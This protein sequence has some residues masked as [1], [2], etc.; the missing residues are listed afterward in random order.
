MK[1]II[2]KRKIY[3]KMLDWKSWSKGQYALLIEGA[4]RIGKSTIAEEFARNEYEDYLI[5]DFSTAKKEVIQAFDYIY[6]LDEFFLILNTIYRKKLPEKKSVIIF[7]EIQFCPKARQAIKHLVKDGRYDYIET[8]SLIS[9]RKNT[10]D[11]LIPSEEHRL[12]MYPMDFEEFLWAIGKAPTFDLIKHSFDKLKP[13]G[14]AMHRLIMTDFR[15]FLLIGGMP[16]SVVAFIKSNDFYEVDRIKREILSLYQEDFRKI[17][18]LGR[19]S[20]IFSSIPSQLSRNTKGFNIGNVIENGRPSRY[21]EIFADLRE[22]KTVN[23]AY[24]AND[25]GIGLSL[26]TDFDDFKMYLAD[27]GLFVSLIY[28]D[29]DYTEN[30]IYKKLLF[31]KLPSDLGFIYE[32]VVAQLLLS[33]GHSLH[34]YTFKRENPDTGAIRQYEID[35]LINTK[36]KISPIEVKSSG[37]TA[38]RSID[39]FQDKYSERILNRYIIFTKDLKKIQDILCLPVYMTGLL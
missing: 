32:N 3:Q 29:K 25:P 6:D 20:T 31:D 2:F 21:G 30:D 1:E 15:K 4:R 35:F 24:K 17:D 39:E 18:P 19:I 11:I 5:I 27:T 22:S 8:G 33:S 38:H 34:Y 26:H 36:S 13:L 14:E 23:F 28:Q 16:Q 37:Y 9:I 7:D 12:S 10:S